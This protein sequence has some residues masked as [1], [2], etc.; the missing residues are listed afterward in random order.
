MVVDTAGG[1]LPMSLYLLENSYVLVRAVGKLLHQN[2]RP[3]TPP[4]VARPVTPEQAPPHPESI[5]SPLAFVDSAEAARSGTSYACHNNPRFVTFPRGSRNR[6]P[7][8]VG[9]CLS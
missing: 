6:S 8:V 4:I 1:Q 9:S 5:P 3:L 2:E 7:A